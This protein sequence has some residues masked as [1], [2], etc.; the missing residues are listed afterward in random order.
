MYDDYELDSL[1]EEVDNL[2]YNEEDEKMIFEQRVN[3]INE[4]WDRENEY[5]KSS[6]IYTEEE[7]QQILENHNR[8]RNEKIAEARKGYEEEIDWI[9][10]QKQEAADDRRMEREEREYERQL[11]IQD[12]DDDDLNAYRA[13]R[14]ELAAYDDFI[15]SMDMADD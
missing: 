5:I 9:R 15:A 8:I 12:S 14:E 11:A 10:Q 2:L 1:M 4:Y 13:Y 6:G 3:E 7:V